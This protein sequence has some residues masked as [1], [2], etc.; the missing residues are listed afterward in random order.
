MNLEYVT[1]HHDVPPISSWVLCP[2]HPRLV[3]LATAK[4]NNA[5]LFTVDSICDSIYSKVKCGIFLLGISD[6]QKVFHFF[7]AQKMTS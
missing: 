4:K 3:M 1:G 6:L 5:A 7:K 2:L